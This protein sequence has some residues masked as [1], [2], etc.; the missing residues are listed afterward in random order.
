VLSVGIAQQL[1]QLQSACSAVVAL[2]QSVHAA[3]VVQLLLCLASWLDN[4]ERIGRL[5]DV[6]HPITACQ[7]QGLVIL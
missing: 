3:A 7:G 4:L 6:F 2:L 1:L 5:P